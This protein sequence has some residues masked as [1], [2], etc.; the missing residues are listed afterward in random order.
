MGHPADAASGWQAAAPQ[1]PGQAGYGYP[2]AGQPGATGAPSWQYDTTAFPAAGGYPAAGAPPAAPPTRS[3]STGTG[4]SKSRTGLLLLTGVLV[5]L[6]AGGIGGYVGSQAAS[7]DTPTSTVSLPQATAGSSERP[8]GTVAAIAEAVSPAVV[9]IA[10]TGAQGSGSGSGF[11]IR[12]NGY[13][14]TNNHVVDGRCRRRHAQGH[15]ADGRGARRR[16]SSAATRTTTSRS[17][18]STRPAC[19]P[20]S[21]GDSDGVVVGDPVDRDRLPAG[22]RRHG[23]GR[24]RQRPQPAGDRRRRGRDGRSSTPSR[25]TPRSTPATPAARWSNAQGRSSASTP[26]SPRSG[27]RQRSERLI[28][29]GFAIPINQAKRIAEELINTGKSTHAGHRG[30]A[31]PEL[32]G[33]GRTRPGGRRPVARRRRPG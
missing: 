22:P 20:W 26:R 1:Y 7:S 17:S 30:L 23:H 14:V 12:P 4:G 5:A 19:R 10:V 11:V 13:I 29:L 6:L 18:R 8:D 33:P 15:F 16:R 25:P 28:G 27:D 32:P 9:S 2:G 31:G 3:T 21:L 24:H